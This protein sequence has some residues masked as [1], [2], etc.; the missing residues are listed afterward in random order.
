MAEKPKVLVLGGAGF[1]GRN[2][3]TYLVQNNLASYIRIADKALLDAA[4]LAP[5]HSDA[6]KNSI[7]DYCQMN[8]VNPAAIHKAFH[9]D[10][11]KFNII[12]NLA[13]ETRFGQPDEVYMEKVVKLA[14]NC[15]EEAVKTKVDKFVEVST[16][17]VY[18]PEGKASKEDCKLQPWTSCAKFK[19][20]AEENLK[21]IKDLPLVIVRP[22]VVYGPG[23][24][25]G[26]CPRLVVGAVYRQLGKKMKLLWTDDLKVNT[27]HVNDVCK[28]LWHVSQN[29]KVGTIWNLA[30]KNDTNQ[31]K[32]NK[33]L[34][35]IF[36][37]KTGFISKVKCQ[38][39]KMN[40][41]MVTEEVN[42]R[43]LKPW[44]DMLKAAGI[45]NSPLSP[46]LEEELLA[47]NNISIDGTAIEST[48]FKYDFPQLT[49]P[50]LREVMDYFVGQNLF[51]KK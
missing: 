38:F 32:I 37:I 19:L 51:P 21:N 49:E 4:F 25:T 45:Q 2:L 15:G 48:G 7:V 1:I 14:T 9:I 28:G 6:F 31:G 47:K 26:L 8:L 29:C 42:R 34:E 43:H 20:L 18:P 13:C 30:D 5:P 27:V 46:Y 11:S 44:S 50:L 3:V 16:Y 33:L 22:A 36:G 41:P 39:A 23:D 35:Q 10:G 40:I 17:Q 24:L 12:F